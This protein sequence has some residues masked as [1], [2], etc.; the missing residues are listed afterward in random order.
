MGFVILT[1]IELNQTNIYKLKM[2]TVQVRKNNVLLLT[3][4]VLSISILLGGCLKSVDNT[5]QRPKTYISFLQLAAKAPSVEL[6]F[7][8]T[9]GSDGFTPGMVTSRYNQ[10]DPGFYSIKFKKAGGDSLVAAAPTM[11]YDS[12]NFYTFL[13]Y[14]TPDNKA[15]AEVIHDDYSVI[16][17]QNKIYYRFFNMAPEFDNVD[18]YFNSDKK[19]SGRTYADNIMGSSYY[20]EFRPI[21]ASS[22]TITVKKAGTDSVISQTNP[23]F[24][25]GNAYTIFLKGLTN[26][27][28]TNTLGIGVLL[29]TLN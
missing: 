18:V 20:N 25:G 13:L 3:V 29:S 9:K 19:E 5:P 4:A 16:T 2:K 12:L 10:I 11:Y 22:Y 15:E 1:D 28:N 24:I 21:D 8:D 23:T 17:D 14:T 26:G 7:N 27:S 6:Y